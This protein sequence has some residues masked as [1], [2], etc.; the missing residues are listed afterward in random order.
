MKI[1]SKL[2]FFRSEVRFAFLRHGNV[3]N[4]FASR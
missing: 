3:K 4:Y 2:A 1:F